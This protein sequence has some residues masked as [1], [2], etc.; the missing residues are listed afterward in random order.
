MDQQ[1]NLKSH[2]LVVFCVH[3][4]NKIRNNKEPNDKMSQNTG[5]IIP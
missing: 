2:K 3:E 1:E 4:K 5:L